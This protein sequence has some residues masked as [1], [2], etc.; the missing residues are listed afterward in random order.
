MPTEDTLRLLLQNKFDRIEKLV[1]MN[2]T[3]TL[4]IPSVLAAIWAIDIRG[5]HSENIWILCVISIILLLIWRS[6]AHYLDNDIA[7]IYPQVLQLEKELSILPQ[8][9]SIFVGLIRGLIKKFH[10]N[11]LQEKIDTLSDDEKIEFIEQLCQNKRLGYRGHLWWDLIT[12]LIIDI[13]TTILLQGS[14]GLFV[15]IIVVLIIGYKLS[16]DYFPIQIDPTE[17]EFICLL[18]AVKKDHGK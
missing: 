4:A 16:Q 8:K 18:Y 7:G 10:S 6:F 11:K 12:L 13:F 17:S 5:T 9:C 1:N 15:I 2:H 14:F 3:A